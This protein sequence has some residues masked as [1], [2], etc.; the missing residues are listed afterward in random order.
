VASLSLGFSHAILDRIRGE[1]KDKISHLNKTP[2]TGCSTRNWFILILREL[3]INSKKNMGFL[4]A[5]FPFYVSF[6]GSRVPKT[7]EIVFCHC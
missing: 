7:G 2:L 1:M 4:S 5:K 6:E 3:A